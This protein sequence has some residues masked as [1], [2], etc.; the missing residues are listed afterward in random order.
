MRHGRLPDE[1]V[2]RLRQAQGWIGGSSPADAVYVPPPPEAVPALF[3]DLV[4]FA[5]SPR[6]PR[7]R[8]RGRVRPRAA[9]DDPPI[10][11]WER[12]ARS[13]ARRLDPGAPHPGGGAAAG[14]RADRPRPR[15]LPLGLAPLPGGGRRPLGCVVRRHRAPRADASTGVVD[16]VAALVDDWRERTA[17][18]RTDAAARA[19]LDLLPST[20]C[21]TR[22][23]CPVPSASRQRAA[24][25]A[26]STLGERGIVDPVEVG[27]RRPGRP[28]RWWVAACDPRRGRPLGGLRQST[29][30]RMRHSPGA[31]AMM[32]GCQEG[33]GATARSGGCGRICG[34]TARQLAIIVATS[35]VSSAGQVAVPLIVKHVIDGPLADWRPR[36]DLRGGPGSPSR[37]RWSRSASPTCVG[38]T[39]P[40]SPPD[41]RRG[42]ATTCT[43][44][45]SGST[46]GSMTAGSQASCSRAR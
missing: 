29:A 16:R 2:G 3:D 31:A 17:D 5:N 37:S 24:R 20:R 10:R 35:I 43:R 7:R 19:A 41:S 39:S 46:S 25:S 44:S 34:P 27:P 26:P 22:R 32:T 21:S 36:R 30:K 8:G 13:G 9:R 18:L 42:C 38:R 15:R 1:M 6:W 11:R 14:Q 12:A 23:S 33:V 28:R 45:C 4:A 40:S